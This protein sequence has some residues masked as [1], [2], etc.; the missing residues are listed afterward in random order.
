MKKNSCVDFVKEI[1]KETNKW[2]KI[3]FFYIL[4]GAFS[5]GN[6]HGNPLLTKQKYSNE[7]KYSL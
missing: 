4:S 6:V 2:N 5:M 7:K 3:E 1:V